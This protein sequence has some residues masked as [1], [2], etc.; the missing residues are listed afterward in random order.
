[1]LRSQSGFVGPLPA[2]TMCPL[3]SL[4]AQWCCKAS[5]E[6]DDGATGVSHTHTLSGFTTHKFIISPVL[7]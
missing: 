6:V 1:M 5:R 4:F 2:V 3:T 7:A